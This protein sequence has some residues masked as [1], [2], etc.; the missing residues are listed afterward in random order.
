MK[1]GLAN[2]HQEHQRINA[3]KRGNGRNCAWIH[4]GKLLLDLH[5]LNDD[6]VVRTIHAV[7]SDATDLRNDLLG[8]LIRHFTENGVAVV[9]V[10]GGRHRDEELGAIGAW[11]SIR[12]GQ[13][14]WAV[15]LQLRVELV[16]ELVAR[17]TTTGARWVTALNH[18]AIDDAVEDRAIV[19]RAFGRALSVWLGVLLRTLCQTNEVLDGLRGVIAEKV[20]GDIALIGMQNCCSSLVSHAVQCTSSIRDVKGAAMNRKTVPTA[21]L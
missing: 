18:E 5:G 14:E 16:L 17:A 7:S 9:Q 11:A 2:H 3:N 10:R 21:R 4:G 8:L 1:Q 12:H 13:Q 19:E 20:D 15:E 6:I